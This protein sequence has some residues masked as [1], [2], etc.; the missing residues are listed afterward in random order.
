M[1]EELGR[2]RDRGKRSD[3]KLAFSFLPTASEGDPKRILL[4]TEGLTLS[5]GDRVLFRDADF[6]LRCGEKLFLLGPNGC[7]KSTLLSVLLGQIPADRGTVRLSSRSVFG[8]MSQSLSFPDEQAT[9]LQTLLSAYDLDEGQAR[10][11]LARYGFRDVDVFKQVRVLSGGE[12]ARLFLC[13]LL[14]DQPDLLFLDEPTNHL[15][16]RSREILEAA[17]MDY[18]GALLVV[19]HD[20]YLIERLSSR[21]LG[22]IGTE[23][24]SFDHYP[25]YQKARDTFTLTRSDMKA[26][27]ESAPVSKSSQAVAEPVRDD[28]DHDGKAGDRS[29]NTAIQPRI[30]R[31]KERREI[32]LRKERIRQVEREI[33]SME[34][35]RHEMEQSFAANAGSGNY[36]VYADLLERL[37]EAYTEFLTLSEESS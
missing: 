7:G 22:F 29:E 9:L 19:S 12:R 37:D 36:D 2:I 5:Y 8:H 20:R 11:L 6:H 35:Q 15:D 33:E 30:N 24:R 32:A 10:S 31:A 23:I 13:Q 16:I 25:A 14:L 21:I 3:T 34:Q 4:A 17:L 18:K 28:S 1:T 27:P 26:G